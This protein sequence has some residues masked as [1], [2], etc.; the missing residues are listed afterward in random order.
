MPFE[1]NSS[2]AQKLLRHFEG[3]RSEVLSLT[4]A[5]C[6]VESPSGDGEG[7][8][9]VVGLIADAASSI[10][11]VESV[12]RVAAPDGY[13]E[14]LLVHAFEKGKDAGGGR[15]LLLLG[16][17]D[18]VH[19][20]GTLAARPWREDEGRIYAPGVFDMKA[21][22]A[23]ALEALRACSALGLVPRRPLT[24]LLTCDEESG[25]MSGRAPV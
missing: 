1:F 14:H 4:R 6:E 22:C 16:H 12:E 20:R 10:G 23:V 11:G 8:R 19:P 3:R 21:S 25:S 24:L 9:A 7:S 15:G 17:T 2:D 13:G 18:T 5:L